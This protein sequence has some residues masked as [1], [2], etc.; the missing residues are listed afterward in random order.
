MATIQLP[1]IPRIFIKA[2]L[3]LHILL[4]SLAFVGFVGGVGLGWH[5]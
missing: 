1:S 2:A 4:V 3:F 5:P